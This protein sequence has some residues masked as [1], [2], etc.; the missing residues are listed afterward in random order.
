VIALVLL[1][2][3]AS[4]LTGCLLVLLGFLM[5]VLLWVGKTLLQQNR[6]IQSTANDSAQASE[7]VASDLY[8]QSNDPLLKE[9]QKRREIEAKLVE[10]EQR[11]RSMVED[12]TEMIVRLNGEGKIV[13]AN[14]SYLSANHITLEQAVLSN[15]FQF[16]DPRDRPAVL[17]KLAKCGT[18]EHSSSWARFRITGRS[19]ELVWEEWNCSTLFGDDGSFSCIQAIGR[20]VTA[21]V[22]AEEKLRERDDQM[23]HVARLTYLGQMMASI[24]HELRQPLSSISNF[25]FATSNSLKL[26]NYD[27]EKLISWNRSIVEEISRADGIIR[28][29][30]GFAKRTSEEASQVSVNETIQQVLLMLDF[31]VR[32]AVAEVVLELDQSDPL[33]FIERLQ[34]EQVLVN[35]ISNACDAIRAADTPAKLLRLKTHCDET[36]VSIEVIDSGTGVKDEDLGKLFQPFFTSKP[37]GMGLGLAI[38]KA[39][40]DEF[41]GDIEAKNISP[42]LAVRIKFPIETRVAAE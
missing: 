28:R 8:A 38:V 12:Q 6:T 26:G 2:E 40:V 31:S 4:I 16:I 37:N 34:L 24:T 10:S 22:H 25:A 7:H 42:G 1:G 36:H 39:I 18:A 32:K 17:R 20:N 9:I 21:L 29:L 23:R 5:A 27:E 30:G 41:E 33:I 13:F 35:L 15:F 14:K 3:I 11:F 19:D